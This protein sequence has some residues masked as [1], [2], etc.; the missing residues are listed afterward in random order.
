MSDLSN[1][2]NDQIVSMGDWI[3]TFILSGIPVV[4]FIMILVWAFGGGAK[5]SKRN[6]AR[7]ALIFAVVVGFISILCSIIFS[8]TLA[9]IASQM[10]SSY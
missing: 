9:A 8:T 4:G 10:S 6:Y 3:V 2:Q 1:S 5:I 7:A